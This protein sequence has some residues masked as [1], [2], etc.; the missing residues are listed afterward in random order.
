METLVS[1]LIF[2]PFYL[3]PLTTVPWSVFENLLQ[4]G[5]FNGQ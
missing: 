4:F 5:K 2:S 1:K 3:L